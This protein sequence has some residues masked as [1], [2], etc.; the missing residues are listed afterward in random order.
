MA[1]SEGDVLMKVQTQNEWNTDYS[2]H[3]QTQHWGETVLMGDWLDSVYTQEEEMMAN[4][5]DS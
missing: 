3:V 5:V 1:W 2:T 4:R